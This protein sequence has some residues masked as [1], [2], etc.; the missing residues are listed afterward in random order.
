MVKGSAELLGLRSLMMDFG[1]D[2]SGILY[3]DSSAALAIAKRKGAGE[4]RHINVSSL[5][6]Q[7]RQDKGELE[8]RKVQGSENPSDLMTKYLARQSIDTCMDTLGQSRVTGRARVGLEVQG[9]KRQSTEIKVA[10]CHEVEDDW[11]CPQRIWPINGKGHPDFSPVTVNG[12]RW[13][14]DAPEEPS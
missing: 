10:K 3:A 5:W 7:E 1:R 14:I 4:L 13:C 9:Q 2:S 12:M 8:Y 6:I 11:M